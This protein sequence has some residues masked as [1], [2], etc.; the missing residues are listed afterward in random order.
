MKWVIRCWASIMA[1][2]VGSALFLCSVKLAFYGIGVDDKG[3]SRAM[4]YLLAVMLGGL[5]SISLAAVYLILKG[6]LDIWKT[7]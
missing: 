1:L 7:N 5:G 6:K 4:D 2:N 3:F